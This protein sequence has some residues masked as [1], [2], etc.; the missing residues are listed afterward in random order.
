MLAE[1]EKC[2][3]DKVNPFSNDIRVLILS[4]VGN[5]FTS[6]IDLKSAATIGNLSENEN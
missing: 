5:N 6:G 4:A 1:I 3:V 2:I